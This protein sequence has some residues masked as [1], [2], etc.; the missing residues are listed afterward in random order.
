MLLVFNIQPK[1]C[2]TDAVWSR[3]TFDPLLSD[4]DI[5]LEL[6]P[7]AKEFTPKEKVRTLN[8]HV[9]IFK[10]SSVHTF[11]LNPLASFNQRL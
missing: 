5:K 6:N 2:P 9:D 1:L 10:P 8:P 3:S 11:Q 7:N 4:N